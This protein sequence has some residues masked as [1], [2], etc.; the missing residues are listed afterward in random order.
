MTRAAGAKEE[1]GA[2]DTEKA[3]D[4]KDTIFDKDDVDGNLKEVKVINYV[5]V[6]V[7]RR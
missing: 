2:K 4:A 3:G 7:D 1:E 5:I 6:G